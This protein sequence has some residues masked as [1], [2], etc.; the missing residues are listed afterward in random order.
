MA[1]DF[2]ISL[3]FI[4]VFFVFRLIKKTDIIQANYV[5]QLRRKR[6]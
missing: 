3:S 5:I 4:P 1:I 2:K 6:T